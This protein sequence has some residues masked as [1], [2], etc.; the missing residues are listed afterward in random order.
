MAI[1]DDGDNPSYMFYNSM[2][3]IVLMSAIALDESPSIVFIGSF[4]QRSLHST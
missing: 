1:K 3:L 2:L 4:I